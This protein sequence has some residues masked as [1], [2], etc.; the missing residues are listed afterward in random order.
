MYFL[1]IV[2][3]IILWES[4]TVWFGNIH[5]SPI[6]LQ[7]P[8]PFLYALTFVS[9]LSPA[10]LNPVAPYI[11]GCAALHWSAVAYLGATLFKKTNSPSHSISQLSIH[12]K[13]GMELHAHLPSSHWGFFWLECVQVFCMLSQMSWAHP[14]SCRLSCTYC[15]LWL[16]LSLYLLL[17]KDPWTVEETQQ[18]PTSLWKPIRSQPAPHQDPSRPA[19]MEVR[20]K[21]ATHTPFLAPSGGGGVTP[22]PS[23]Y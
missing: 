14:C 22:T 1:F 6:L 5:P 11:A 20:P 12:L 9:F 23:S 2:I 7:N 15:C 17:I 3:L 21:Q 4:H 18:Q 10:P 8:P 13:L 16:F 19:H